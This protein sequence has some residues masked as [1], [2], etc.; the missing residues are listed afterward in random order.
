MS[1]VTL[2]I[3]SV[4]QPDPGYGGYGFVR[5]E[6]ETRSGQAGGDRRTT[7]VKMALTGLVRALESLAE[8]PA[9]ALVTLNIADP[10]TALDLRRLLAADPEFAPEDET[11]LW[12]QIISLSRARAGRIGVAALPATAPTAGFVK[13]WADFGADAAKTRGAFKAAIPRPNLLKFPV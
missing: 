5:I 4:C 1:Q 12:A 6:G 13:A 3:A 7:G 9:G 2:W 8:T 10:D 11:E